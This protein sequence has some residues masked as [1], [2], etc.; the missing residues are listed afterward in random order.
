VNAWVGWSLAV[1]G[2]AAGYV[3]WG[4]QGVVLGITVIAFWLLLQFSRSLRVLQRAGRAPIGHV[5]NAVMLQSKLQQGM[6]LMQ[7]LQLTKSLGQKLSESPESWG[8]TDAGGDQLRLV[9]EG[10]KLQSWTLNR[11][12]DEARPAA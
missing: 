4:W 7:V 12:A 9:F 11:A 2:I 8:W 3:G 6:L 10:G 1:A 5:D